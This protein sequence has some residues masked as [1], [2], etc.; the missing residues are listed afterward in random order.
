VRDACSK[1]TDELNS[2]IVRVQATFVPTIAA[3]PY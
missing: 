3:S 1:M 2:V